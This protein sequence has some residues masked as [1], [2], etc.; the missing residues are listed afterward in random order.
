MLL[1]AYPNSSLWP[2]SAVSDPPRDFRLLNQDVPPQLVP[3]YRRRRFL[4][5]VLPLLII[6]IEVVPDPDEL[7]VAVGS[8]DDDDR[9]IEDVVRLDRGQQMM[10]G[11]RGGEVEG[12]DA[13]WYGTN[14]NERQ[15]GG[16][17]RTVNGKSGGTLGGVKSSDVMAGRGRAATGGTRPYRN[18]APDHTPPILPSR[19]RSTA[20]PDLRSPVSRR[21]T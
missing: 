20:I 5:V 11:S 15:R 3:L 21:S 13:G 2:I 10:S 6:R 19:H 9:D 17:A 7:L 1:P 18:P 14:W 8:G 12:V 16:S 4:R